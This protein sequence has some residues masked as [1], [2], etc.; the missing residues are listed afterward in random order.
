MEYLLKT[1]IL[2]PFLRPL[3]GSTVRLGGEFDSE[4]IIGRLD[5]GRQPAAQFVVIEIGM[6]VGEN[7]APRRDALDPVERLGDGEMTRM[8]L[9]APRIGEPQNEARQGPAAPRRQVAAD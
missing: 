3:A 5:I 8:R 6:Q 4:P 7:R 9:V 2:A 1:R